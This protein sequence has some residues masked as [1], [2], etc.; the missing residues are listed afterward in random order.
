MGDAGFMQEQIDSK[1]DQGF[2]CL[3]M[4]IG[5]IDWAKEIELLKG[6][7]SR[8]SA[9]NPYPTCRCEWRLCTR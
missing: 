2:S 8:Y 4:K 9:R 6:L 7:R 3:K 5:A 1:L